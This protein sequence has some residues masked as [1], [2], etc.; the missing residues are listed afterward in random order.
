MRNV[1]AGKS[2]VWLITLVIASSA[3]ASGS[4]AKYH[5]KPVS[6]EQAKEYGL[7]TSFY[8]KCTLV[9]NILIATSDRVSNHAHLEAAYQF[10]RIMKSINPEVAQR[11]RDRK[12]LCSLIGH[13]ELTSESPQ[14]A[15]DKTGNQLDFYNWRRRG[16]LTKIDDRPTVVFAEEDVL[17]YEGG[18]QL[19]SILIHE[20][21]HVIHGAG[22]DEGCKTA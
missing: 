3:F 12:V 13:Q 7:D 18:M 20:F 14:F 16:F 19:E 11:V 15:T 2:I 4:N 1:Y 22:F 10:D 17:E 6:D 8:K 9:Q 5:V 21:G